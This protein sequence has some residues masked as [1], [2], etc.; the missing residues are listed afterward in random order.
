MSSPTPSPLQ[1]TPPRRIVVPSTSRREVIVATVC[2]LLVLVFVVYGILTMTS[3][4][5]AASSNT[6]TGKIVSMRFTPGPEEQISF[7]SKGAHQQHVAGEYLLVVHVPSENRT[8]E[9]PVDA[10]TYAAM[11]PGSAFSFM[12]PRSEQKR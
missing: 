7:G 10:N 1:P 2:G 4:Q 6:L 8:F 5:Q 9:V 11:R 12:R 3:R